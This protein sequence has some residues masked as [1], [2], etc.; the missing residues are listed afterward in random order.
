[1]QFRDF[2]KLHKL[3]LKRSLDKSFINNYILNPTR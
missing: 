2:K 1:M 3:P